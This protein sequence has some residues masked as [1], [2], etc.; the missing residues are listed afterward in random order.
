MKILHLITGLSRGGAEHMLYKL[1]SSMDREKFDH[2]VVS[3][4]SGGV[5]AEKIAALGVPVHSID[6]RAGIPSP[7]GLLRLRKLTRQ[8][9]P[10]VVHAWM[11]HAA[12]AAILAAQGRPLIVAIRNALSDIGREKFLT[13]QVISGLG[14]MSS[15][16]AGICYNSQLNRRQHEAIGYN[17]A[18]GIVIPNGFDCTLLQ[19]RP[20]P[21]ALIR[22]ELGLLPE[23]FVVGHLGR[24]HP[25]KDHHNL[26]AAFARL[27]ASHP[28]A[29]LLMAGSGVDLKNTTLK[30]DISARGLQRRVHLLGERDDVPYLINAFDVLANASRSEAF[31]NVL[32]EGMAC[33]VPC[34][35]TDV[36][37]SS[38]IIGDT[39]IIVPPN[40][41]EALAAALS[42][43]ADMSLVSRA[44]MGA[45]ARAR[46][47][48][49]FSLGRV[50][51]DYADLYEKILRETLGKPTCTLEQRVS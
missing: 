16:A 44:N 34:V 40:D 39:G 22:T 9:N 8:I 37:D 5:Y 3:M 47:I 10:D 7:W 12:L 20:T 25:V 41:P 17:D 1:L 45:R 15:R 4:V 48:E 38:Y 27:S 43:M 21:R 49:E 11:Y 29:H 42:R 51:E 18:K 50:A 33:G 6:I 26:L 23:N 31:P 35:A 36:G 14:R 28:T 24:Y 19:P 46:I 2:I 32:G 13:R 30:A